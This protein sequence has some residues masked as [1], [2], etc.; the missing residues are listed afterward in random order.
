MNERAPDNEPQVTGWAGRRTLVALATYNELSNLPSLV[1]DIRQQMPTADILVVD[2]NSPDGTGDWCRKQALDHAHFHVIHRA[3]KLGL[4]S[5]MVEAIRFA[6][7]GK[8]IAL[9]TMDADGSHPAEYL[10]ALATGLD[11]LELVVGSRY[12]NGGGIIGW[13][14]RRRLMSRSVNW[15]A[16]LLLGLK[17]RDT[18][19]AYRA[20][21]LAALEQLDLEMIRSR[22]FAILEELLWQLN[23]AGV[24]IGEVPIQFRDRTTGDSKLGP[25]EAIRSIA[26]LLRMGLRHR[27]WY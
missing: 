8:Y 10:P 6:I 12:C 16:R 19:G 17:V 7:S 26:M 11:E 4:G 27:L 3:E 2:D 23:R 1:S 25:W 18:S 15:L 20:Y 13:S 9:I 5:A 21:R 14:W 22:G 24:R